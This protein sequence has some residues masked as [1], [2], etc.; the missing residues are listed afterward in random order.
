MSPEGPHIGLTE[1]GP[2]RTNHHVVRGSEDPYH[3][4]THSSTPSLPPPN[5]N[6]VEQ[7]PESLVVRL[8]PDGQRISRAGNG[9]VG[10]HRKSARVK[11]SRLNILLYSHFIYFFFFTKKKHPLINGK[12]F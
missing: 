12:G 6:T 5:L 4:L 3:S 11:L 10:M 2:F 1:L 8:F 9:W 7:I